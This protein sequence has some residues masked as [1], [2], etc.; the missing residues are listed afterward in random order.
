MP[1][2]RPNTFAQ[3]ILSLS[4]FACDKAA[5][6]TFRVA[7]HPTQTEQLC[8]VHFFG[9]SFFNFSIA[10]VFPGLSCNDFW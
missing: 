3:T 10:F 4:L 5:D 7:R 8:Q 2:P 9:F 1:Q 6:H